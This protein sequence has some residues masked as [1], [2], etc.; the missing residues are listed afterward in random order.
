M[1]NDKAKTC[2][3]TPQTHPM[4]LGGAVDCFVCYFFDLC[5][6]LMT[7]LAIT[8]PPA[9]LII[10]FL[11]QFSTPWPTTKPTPPPHTPN[12]PNVIGRC[13]WLLCVLFFDLCCVLMAFLAIALPPASLINMFCLNSER[14]SQRRSQHHPSTPHF[15]HS[16]QINLIG[17]C[18]W[19]LCVFYF[20]I[21]TG[22][23]H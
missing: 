5:C 3:H 6:V 14:H 15:N 10:I 13:C 11:P 4:S 7:F 1:D 2:P 23:I 9:S 17:W 22:E 12:S 20:I 18:Y 21:A 8:L 16:H 19:L